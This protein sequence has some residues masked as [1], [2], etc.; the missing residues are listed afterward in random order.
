MMFQLFSIVHVEKIVW[1]LL[2]SAPKSGEGPK[3]NIYKSTFCAIKKKRWTQSSVDCTVVKIWRV[4][5]AI[6]RNN[7]RPV[8]LAK[9]SGLL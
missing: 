7:E 1:I 4:V 3:K 2:I 5:K 6:K 9:S 8:E